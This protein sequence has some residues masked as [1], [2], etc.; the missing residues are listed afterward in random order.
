MK[1]QSTIETLVQSHVELKTFVGARSTIGAPT[2]NTEVATITQQT[3]NAGQQLE[4][5][6]RVN[7]S[8]AREFATA[9]SQSVPSP[10]NHGPVSNTD[11]SE[12]EV[13]DTTPEWH[14]APSYEVVLLQHPIY[15]RVQTGHSISSRTASRT[16]GVPWSFLSG[17]SISKLSRIAVLELP[18]TIN[19][20][21][22]MRN[23]STQEMHQRRKIPLAGKDFAIRLGG[24]S[25]PA[26]VA[27]LPWI[28]GPRVTLNIDSPGEKVVFSMPAPLFFAGM[29]VYSSECN[30]I[31][32]VPFPRDVLLMTNASFNLL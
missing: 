25:A 21:S 13:V 27:L 20:L 23:Y 2:L 30:A 29:K 10:T 12:G 3:I 6:G 24:P 7:E 14:E 11:G 31:Y 4:E 15:R 1:L 28:E 19:E 32:G 9:G 16:Y 22:E 26:P 5:E 17:F 8:P 18:I